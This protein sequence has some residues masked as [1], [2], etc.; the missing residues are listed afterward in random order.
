MENISLFQKLTQSSM[1]DLRVKLE[2]TRRDLCGLRINA[3]TSQVKDCSQYKKL[4]KHIARIL[5]AIRAREMSVAEN[6][7]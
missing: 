7:K 5:T 2:A 1:D 6:R 4:R 3:T